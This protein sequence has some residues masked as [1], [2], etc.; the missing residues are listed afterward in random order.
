MSSRILS[1]LMLLSLAGCGM[2]REPDNDREFT[3]YSLHGNN[4]EPSKRPKTAEEFCSFPVLGKR[5]IVNAEDQ[6]AILT[7]VHAGI[8]NGEMA[9]CFWPRHG[10]RVVSKL[11]TTYYLICYECTTIAIHD[12][13]SDETKA[14][15]R[16]SESVLNKYLQG[17]VGNS[18]DRAHDK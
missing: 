4:V 2:N 12:G 11:Q 17:V 14:I 15:D 3:L 13:M 9:K 6:N 1:L 8:G 7:A 16:T 5:K 10:I 18:E